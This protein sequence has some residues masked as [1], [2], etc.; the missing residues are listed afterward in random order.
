MLARISFH[1]GFDED[2]RELWLNAQQASMSG[3]SYT[4]ELHILDELKKR[5]NHR[6]KVFKIIFIIWPF[7]LLLALIGNYT[8]DKYK[9]K[10]AQTA[11][12]DNQQKTEAN[13]STSKSTADTTNNLHQ[14][15]KTEQSAKTTTVKKGDN[16]SIKPQ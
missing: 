5:K 1:R 7:L 14:N 9:K 6:L 2:S 4:R 10:T 8:W 16:R 12:I 15:Q 3:I 11:L 13:K